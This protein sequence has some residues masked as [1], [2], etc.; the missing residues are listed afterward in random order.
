[1]KDIEFAPIGLSNMLNTGGAVQAFEFSCDGGEATVE[2]DDP[3]I[4]RALARA[5]LIWS[6][7]ICWRSAS[8]VDCCG[9]C[10]PVCLGRSV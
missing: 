5:C 6:V 3:Q 1:M 7:V 8:N 2:V 4:Y 9:T 10:C